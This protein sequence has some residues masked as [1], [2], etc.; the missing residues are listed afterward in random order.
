M[1]SYAQHIAARCIAGNNGD[2]GLLHFKLAEQIDRVDTMCR[3]AGGALV[4]RQI[5][6]TIIAAW[7]DTNLEAKAYGD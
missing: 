3:R 4:S 5:I 2:P 6:S 7:I 1:Y